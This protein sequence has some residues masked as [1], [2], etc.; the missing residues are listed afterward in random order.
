MAIKI[1]TPNAEMRTISRYLWCLF[2]NT[3]DNADVSTPV[4]M[5]EAP[6]IEIYIFEK[7]TGVNNSEM[8]VPK[9]RKLPWIR[10]NTITNKTK[11]GSRIAS[12]IVLQKEVAG[13]CSKATGDGGESGLSLRQ[14]M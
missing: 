4:A 12:L 7:P 13:A 11:F 9:A 2:S 3:P 1:K 8:L 6:S 5:T 14:M 10:A